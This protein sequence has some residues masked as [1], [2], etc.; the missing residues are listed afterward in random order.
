MV[1]R[2]DG[3]W[4]CFWFWFC[5][6]WADAGVTPS[7]VSSWWIRGGFY[8]LVSLPF[9]HRDAAGNDGGGRFLSTST[10]RASA[11]QAMAHW[12]KN[13]V[14]SV[15]IWCPPQRKCWWNTLG[16]F[17]LV[18]KLT[19]CFHELWFP[20][21]QGAKGTRTAPGSCVRC[22][23]SSALSLTQAG[24]FLQCALTSSLEPP[25]WQDKRC[26]VFERQHLETGAPLRLSSLPSFLLWD[27]VDSY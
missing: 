19:F 11:T 26:H 5:V 7:S 25:R 14:L 24:G 2:T 3:A 10:P 8:R 4:S 17:H 15:K 18:P 23:V 6:I 12:R 27:F 9:S 21:S 13:H 1:L 20:S 22:L 16:G